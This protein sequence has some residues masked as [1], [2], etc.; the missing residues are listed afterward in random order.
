MN[1]VE[2]AIVIIRSQKGSWEDSDFQDFVW[3]MSQL[4]DHDVNED[5]LE[6]Y[7]PEEK[8]V[9]KNEKED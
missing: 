8:W 9:D 6:N 4:I 5:D 1:L 7:S 2:F 3:K